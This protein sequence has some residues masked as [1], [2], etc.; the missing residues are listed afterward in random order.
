M[1]DNNSRNLNSLVD[2]QTP[3]PVDYIKGIGLWTCSITVGNDYLGSALNCELGIEAFDANGISL[4]VFAD[5]DDAINTLFDRWDVKPKAASYEHLSE[6]PIPT[7]T[8]TP[9]PLQDEEGLSQEDAPSPQP[10]P[11]PEGIVDN[12]LAIARGYLKRGWN[13]VPVSRRTKKPIGNSWQHRRLDSETAAAAFNRADMNVGVQLGPMSNGLTDVDLDCREAV[14]IGLMLLPESNNIFGRAGKL[15]SHW[16]YGTTL[17]DKI[18]KACLQFKDVDGTMMLELKI[19]GGG[20][21]SQSVFPGSTHTSGEAI[22]WD[23]DGALV[24]VDDNKLLRQIRRLAVAVMLARHW[25]EEGARHDAALTVGGFLARAGLDGSEVALMLGAIA[26]AAEDEQWEDRV[27]AGRDAVKQYGDGGET[28]GL[29]ALAK[30]FDEKIAGKAAEWLGYRGGYEPD[31][32]GL[33]ELIIGHEPTAVAKDLAKLIARGEHYFFNGNT[34]VRVAAEI[35]DMPRAIEVTAENVRVLAHEISNPIKRTKL[36]I[37]SAEVK[38]DVANIYLKGLEGRWGLKRFTGI[39]TTPIL[40]GDGV[41]RSMNGYDYATGLWC[42]NVPAL[43]IPENPTGREAA[44]ALLRV[45]HLF[46]TFPF[47]D[48]ARVQ[49]RDLGVEVVEPNEPAGLDESAFLV[50]LLTAACADLP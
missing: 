17:A 29:P 48:A 5:E 49:D 19:G 9:S 13:P 45:R 27:Q 32:G 10:P 23:R 12:P 42:H 6:A 15:Q 3:E 40:S 41:I 44:A 18:A 1:T 11:S 35:D 47:A 28:R 22:E 24:S 26:T 37:T 43:S 16:L 33:P 25:P 2:R 30:A 50:A 31:N 8:S 38:L 39:A 21:G 7:V 46:R 14:A 34:P 20:K 4:G 36:G